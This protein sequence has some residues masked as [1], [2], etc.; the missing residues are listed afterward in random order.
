MNDIPIDVIYNFI[1]LYLDHSSIISLT[2]TCDKFRNLDWK[3]IFLNYNKINKTFSYIPKN[4]FYFLFLKYRR[5]HCSAC[6]LKGHLINPFFTN[7]IL[8]PYCN[9]HDKFY[10]IIDEED[11]IKK[12]GSLSILHKKCLPFFNNV[13]HYLL[14]DLNCTIVNINIKKRNIINHVFKILNI[15]ESNEQTINFV[16]III[17]K[18]ITDC[19]LISNI[20]NFILSIYYLDSNIPK[21]ELNDSNIFVKCPLKNSIISYIYKLLN[22]KYK[23]NKNTNYTYADDIPNFLPNYNKNFN[24]IRNWKNIDFEKLFDFDID[25]IKWKET[26]E[27]MGI[28]KIPIIY[29]LY[30]MNQNMLKYIYN[31]LHL[32]NIYKYT[33]HQ[34][35]VGMID[36][37]LTYFKSN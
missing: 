11:A 1:F 36:C 32:P 9:Y 26:F 18:R 3:I 4:Q 16:N 23:F 6:L 27:S 30:F 7:S 15:P 34:D 5:N 37:I 31:H 14:S 8:C 12:Y 17:N 33:K 24:C 35:I 25:I 29:D 28:E 21:L 13:N 20:L 22:F 10:G 19:N 2:Q